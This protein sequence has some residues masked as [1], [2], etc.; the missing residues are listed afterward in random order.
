MLQKNCLASFRT[1]WSKCHYICY[2]ANVRLFSVT[3]W[4]P[5]TKKDLFQLEIQC[6]K[7]TALQASY[8]CFT[9]HIVKLCSTCVI[10]RIV[11][12]KS[13]VYFSMVSTSFDCVVVLFMFVH[14]LFMAFKSC[15]H[16]FQRFQSERTMGLLRWVQNSYSICRQTEA[17]AIYFCKGLSSKHILQCFLIIHVEELYTDFM[18]EREF[19][20][21]CS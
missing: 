11:S 7:E 5:E 19:I 20:C 8:I 9:W 10:Y 15:I 16:L 3:Q 14:Y 4:T 21:T 6:Y 13:F 2:M 17:T 12:V 18:K 1:F